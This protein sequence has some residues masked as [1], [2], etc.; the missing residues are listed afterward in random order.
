MPLNGGEETRILDA[1]EFW[2]DWSLADNGIYFLEGRSIQFFDFA[3]RQKRSILTLDRGTTGGL[4]IS[5]DHKS[6]LFSQE[7]LT[8]ANIVLVRNFQ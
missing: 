7:K 6:L 4:A 5:P 1:P 3:S 8:E 2:Y